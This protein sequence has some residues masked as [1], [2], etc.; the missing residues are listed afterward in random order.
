MHNSYWLYFIKTFSR[1]NISPQ[2][3]CTG[4]WC[5]VTGKCHGMIYNIHTWYSKFKPINKTETKLM[6]DCY[7]TCDCSLN[8]IKTHNT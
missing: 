2:N 7:L 3:I 1:S 8:L 5:D 6:I 4:K